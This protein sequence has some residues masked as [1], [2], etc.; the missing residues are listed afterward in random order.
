MIKL[1]RSLDF[2]VIAEQ[3]EDNASL[4]M[5]RQMGVDFVQGYA[6]GRPQHFPMAA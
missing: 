6:I 4:D 5:V 2:K 1:A 3:V